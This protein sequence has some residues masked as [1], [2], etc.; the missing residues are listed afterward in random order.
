MSRHRLASLLLL[1]ALALLPSL[2]A[3]PAAP[4]DTPAS[5]LC[6]DRAVTVAAPLANAW[7]GW[8]PSVT[9]TRFQN[10]GAA[11]L[12]IDQVSRLKLK[13]AFGFD[14]DMIVFSLPSVIGNNLF[15]GSAS[16]KVYALDAQSGCTH[17][18][19]QAASAVRP[20]MVM[21]PLPDSAFALLFGDR[22]GWFYSVD[23]ATGRLLWKKKVDDH[24]AARVTGTAVVQDGV[25]YIPVASAEETSA[26]GENYACCSFRGSVVALRVPDGSQLWKTYMISEEARPLAANPTGVETWGPSGAGIWSA[27]TIDAKRSLLY[28]TTGD[29]YSPPA[30]AM[31]DAVVALD[32]KT[33]RIAWARQTIPG[34]VFNGNCQVKNTCP[35]PDYVFGSSLILEHV[36]D[37]DILL[38]GQKSG[39]VY[40]LDPDNKGQ[41]L[42]QVRVGKGGVNG[43]VQWGM[44]SDG[45]QLYA[46]TS[47]VVRRGA[48]GYDP[49]QGGGLTAL[50][51]RD[52]EKAWY[53][54]PQPCGDKPGCS[55]P[56]S[57]A[58]TAIP[59]VVFSGSLD[60]HLRAY[61]AEDGNVLWDFDTVRD[62]PTV[63]G[64]KARGGGVDGP[65]PVVANGMLYIGSGYARTGGM[66][67][68]VL[69][70][71]A[72]GE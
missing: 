45:K 36:D 21:A 8:S 65:G 67:G 43:G 12:T 17:W 20:A 61:S 57:A 31:S 55:P 62:F 64:I 29:N 11:G 35:G 41:I 56:Q 23:A 19:Y 59:G 37:H 15:V 1:C 69:L 60:G 52:G 54:E 49:K 24:P 28:V 5:G 63:N 18:T 7:N 53:A 38:A 51:I 13:W 58:V 39:M 72:P 25:V 4:A 2:R 66:G 10:S 14:G 50:S 42:W 47:D 16:G 33:G 70:A 9:N 22:S 48:A 71:F 68:N 40:G 44:A 46:A 34:D 6:S 32:L 26:R 27:P 3:Q 30:T